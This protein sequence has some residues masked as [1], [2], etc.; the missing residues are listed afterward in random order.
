[1]NV[2]LERG[3]AGGVVL[4]VLG[5][6]QTF[7]G[8]QSN[9]GGFAFAFAARGALIL[10]VSLEDGWLR[11][12]AIV[13]FWIGEQQF[14]QLLVAHDVEDEACDDESGEY[15]DRVDDAA[16]ALPALAFGVEEDLLVGHFLWCTQLRRTSAKRQLQ[17]TNARALALNRQGLD[18]PYAVH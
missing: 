4:D 12:C 6:A 14:R 9:V 3:V 15:G 2:L 13:V 10:A 11:Q 17:P 5:G 8:V 7:T 16:K 18:V 1:M